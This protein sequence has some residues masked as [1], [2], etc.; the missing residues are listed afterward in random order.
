MCLK[1]EDLDIEILIEEGFLIVQL[2]GFDC[3]GSYVLDESSIPLLKL[4][5]ELDIL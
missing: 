1:E 4:K 2:K 5:E 3:H